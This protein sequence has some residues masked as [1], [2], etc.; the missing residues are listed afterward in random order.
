MPAAAAVL[1][2]LLGLH[3]LLWRIGSTLNL[4]SPLAASLSLLA[5]AAELSMLASF[6]LLLA[7]SLW[8]SPRPATA[9]LVPADG[10]PAGDS[11]RNLGPRR[12]RQ[13]LLRGG[14]GRQGWWQGGACRG[15]R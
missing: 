2:T 13:R 15:S 10:Q 7:F 4:A 14:G 1:L 12:P 6:F 8:P 3:Y 5:L 9:S 11:A